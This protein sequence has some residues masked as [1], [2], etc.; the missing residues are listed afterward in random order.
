MAQLGSWYS[1]Q[2]SKDIMSSALGAAATQSSPGTG[3]RYQA[4][5][6]GFLGAHNVMCPCFPGGIKP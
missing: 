6:A 3:C 2:L 4:H 1:H 5:Q